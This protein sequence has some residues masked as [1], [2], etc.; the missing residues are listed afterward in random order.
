MA[1]AKCPHCKKSVQK[2]LLEEVPATFPDKRT[3]EFG[4]Y[5]LTCSEPECRAVLTAALK[6]DA[7]TSR[8]D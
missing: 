6:E 4:A 7:I 3:P 2:V 1:K 8:I 5:L